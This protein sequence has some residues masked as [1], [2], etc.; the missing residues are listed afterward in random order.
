ML[1]AM[2]QGC[3]RICGK[4]QGYLG[5]PVRDIIVNDTVN[6]PGTPAMETAWTPTPDELYR[7]KHGANVILRILGQMPPPQMITVGPIPL[8][9]PYAF[10]ESDCPGHVASKDN[11][12]ICERC[13]THI[14]ELRPPG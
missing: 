7:L 5:L 8:T 2:I 14:D 6:G 10:V 12:Q 9:I 11:A 1:I 13:G 4:A 3:T